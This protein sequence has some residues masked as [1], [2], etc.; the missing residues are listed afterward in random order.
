MSSKKKDENKID[1]STSEIKNSNNI[2]VYRD[3][4]FNI[5]DIVKQGSL[6]TLILFEFFV[7]EIECSILSS[8]FFC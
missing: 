2:K 5:G 7:S 6:Y 8:S 1:Q 3:P 4:L